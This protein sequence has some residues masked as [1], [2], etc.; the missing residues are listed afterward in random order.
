MSYG[1]TIWAISPVAS[2]ID[3]FFNRI[4][5]PNR[6]ESLTSKLK[7]IPLNEELLSKILDYE[8]G[9]G[10]VFITHLRDAL[11]YSLY[12]ITFSIRASTGKLR[13]KRRSGS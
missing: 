4:G 9:S 7:E 13:E 10:N 5:L 11:Q 2:F 3:E 12:L 6:L 8:V 1:C